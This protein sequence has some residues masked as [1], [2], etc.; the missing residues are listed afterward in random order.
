MKLEICVGSLEAARLVSQMAVD[1]IETCVALEVGGLTP[2]ESMVRWIND[3]FDLEQH[4]LIR[5]RAGGFHYSYD[6]LVVMRDQITSMRQL[7]VRG[8]V[9]GALT[10]ERT[11]DLNALET[12]KRAA[13]NLELTF[14]RAFD[15]VA[16]WKIALDQLV[17]LGFKRI[18]TSGQQRSV[19]DG[20]ECLREMVAYSGSRIEIMAG[21][22]VSVANA[23]DLVAT[24]VDALH[25]SGTLLTPVDTGSLFSTESLVAN[26]EKLRA[27]LQVVGR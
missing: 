12:W 4:V 24:G 6:E 18:L 16:D 11:L 21:G 7:N 15:D 2:S 25:F 13:G 17:K 20:I 23:P 3:T 27:I 9:I 1:R 19:A 10:P 22:G 5:Q 14:H 8:V 26:T